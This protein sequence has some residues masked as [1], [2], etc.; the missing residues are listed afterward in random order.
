MIKNYKNSGIKGDFWLNELNMDE[1][2]PYKKKY[3]YVFLCYTTGRPK[4]MCTHENFNCDF[5]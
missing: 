2:V 5:D 1:Y 4:K 3:F